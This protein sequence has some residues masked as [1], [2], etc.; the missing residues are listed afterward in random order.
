[1]K[2]NAYDIDHLL[3]KQLTGETTAAEKALVQEWLAADIANQH[4]FDHFTLIWEES[5][6]LA[7]TTSV[8]E[9]VA[10]ERFQQRMEPSPERLAP[11]RKLTLPGA[12]WLRIAAMVVLAAGI[13]WMAYALLQKNNVQ[14]ATLATLQTDTGVLTDTL[15]DGSLVTLNKHSQVSYP[16]RFKDKKRNIALKGE[17]FFAVTPDKQKPFVVQVNDITVQVT[18]TSFNIRNHGDTTEVIV[19]TGTVQV[20]H[21]QQQVT[22]YAGEQV[23]IVSATTILQKHRSTDELHKYYRNRKLV[24]DNTPLWRLVEILNE[25]Y[26]APVIIENPAIRYLPINTTFDNMSLD[27][28]MIVISQTLDVKVTKRNGQIILR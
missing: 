9:Q 6:H 24:C 23:M 27:G 10:W 25:A 28:I 5:I 26:D 17:A 21:Q 2:T 3:V 19:E 22:L 14:P 11:I 13:G 16:T 1:L 12:R 18:G 7:A 15:P 20:A 4:Y 8:D